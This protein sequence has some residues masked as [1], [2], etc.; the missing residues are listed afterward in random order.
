MPEHNRLTSLDGGLASA[1]TLAAHGTDPAKA[2][3]RMRELRGAR[4]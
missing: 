4:S 3:H 2:P 1:A